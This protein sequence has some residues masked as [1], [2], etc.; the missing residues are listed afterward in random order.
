MS[1]SVDKIVAE[2][3]ALPPQVRALVAEK[4]IESL[5]A[6][7]N[8]EISPAWR[9]EVRRRCREADEGTVELRNAEDVF[10]KAYS[11]LG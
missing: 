9:E 1:T 4:L 5:D 8:A 2:A 6:E 10:A 11:A 3:L 7:P